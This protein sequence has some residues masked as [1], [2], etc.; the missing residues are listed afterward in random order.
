M[1]KRLEKRFVLTVMLSLVILLTGLLGTINVVNAVVTS[2]QTDDILEV[3]SVGEYASDFSRNQFFDRRQAAVYFTV[4]VNANGSIVACDTSKISTLSQSEAIEIAQGIVKSGKEQG[5]TG[6]FKYKK[7]EKAGNFMYAYYFLDVTMQR[8]A[9]WTVAILSLAIGI[10]CILL[11]IYPVLIISKKAIRPIAEN[12]EKQKQFVTD[13]GHELKTPLAIIMSNTEAMELRTGEN[14]YSKNIRTQVVRLNSLMQNLLTLSKSDEMSDS[15]SKS[16]FCI[17]DVANKTINMFSEAMELKRLTYQC[18]IGADIKATANKEMITNLFSI[19]ADNAVQYAA[20]GGFVAVQLIKNGKNT[21]FRI[22]NNCLS[23]PQCDADK[24]FDRFYRD[25]KA[26]TQKKGGSGIGL[27][28]AKSIAD[29]H[30][31]K[32]KAEYFPDNVIMFTVI[33]P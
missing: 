5:K 8:A 2:K 4:Y 10:L 27:S 19:L 16:E 17:S 7:S 18:E 30:G 20:D 14:K 15:L 33:L 31:G 1:I 29:A 26:R 32:I 12:I 24:L 13:A 23:L 6:S 25:D 28:A 21:E 9:V 3:V 22:A 11:M